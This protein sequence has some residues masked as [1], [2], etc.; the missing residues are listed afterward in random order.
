MKKEIKAE[1]VAQAV[2][3]YI[4]LLLIVLAIYLIFALL[5]D[6]NIFGKQADQSTILTNLF[7]WSATLYTPFL[8]YMA[9]SDWKVQKKYDIE[10]EYA[11][12]AIHII[13][14]INKHF[15]KC[16]YTYIH[17]KELDTKI[18][19]LNNKVVN[20]DFN[21]SYNLYDLEII[22][23]TLQKITGNKIKKETIKDFE[24]YTL[25]FN[26]SINRIEETY[27]NYYN[28]LDDK[29]KEGR[30]KLIDKKSQDIPIHGIMKEITLKNKYNSA[31]VVQVD[32]YYMGEYQEFR[33]TFGGFKKDFDS[34]FE[35]ITN[36][37]INI[38]KI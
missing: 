16:F 21:L 24:D 5:V 13:Y 36:E 28:I 30:F 29:N 15:N 18:V 38:I 35:K 19:Y 37:L 6:L 17:L 4:L 34:N 14:N 25:V 11:D 12:K 33:N 32:H 31:H 26:E 22:F 3:G 1:L 9:Y 7:I 8:A 2:I 27:N 10:K 23:M 20:S